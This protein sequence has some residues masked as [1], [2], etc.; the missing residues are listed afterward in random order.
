MLT[1]VTY[2]LLPYNSM[3]RADFVIVLLHMRV[4]SG[5]WP[6]Q[7]QNW[8]WPHLENNVNS[9]KT[10]QIWAIN[11]VCTVNVAKVVQNMT[12]KFFLF[13]Y[14]L[15]LDLSPSPNSETV[16]WHVS[17]CLSQTLRPCP[18]VPLVDSR[19]TH[20]QRLSPVLHVPVSPSGTTHTSSLSCCLS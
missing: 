4:R 17:I 13:I 10:I 7:T 8:Y 6:V 20:Q 18:P 5:L 9:Q 14:F 15:F 16:I 19:F 12:K 1:S 2:I 3:L 11:I